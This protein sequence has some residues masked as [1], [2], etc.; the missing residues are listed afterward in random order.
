MTSHEIHDLVHLI[1]EADSLKKAE[2]T[3]LGVIL[4]HA[5]AD[6]SATI[7]YAD[8]ATEAEYSVASMRISA[9]SLER[10]GLL[11]RNIHRI[12]TTFTVDV[13]RLREL[14]TTPAERLL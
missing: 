13:V 9:R 1:A 6:H 14:V 2:L 8:L 3:M 12:H 10:R 11:T 5:S 7:P 4:R